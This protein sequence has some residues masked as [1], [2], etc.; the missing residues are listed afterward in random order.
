[1]PLGIRPGATMGVDVHGPHEVWVHTCV[2]DCAVGRVPRE[3]SVCLWL[4]KGHQG[5]AF[6]KW[7]QYCN[8]NDLVQVLGS[9]PYHVALG[10]FLNFSGPQ[11]P[12]LWEVIKG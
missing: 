5:L 11:F 10:N 9:S 1:M 6:K 7:A 3:P 4:H 12:H 8:K 2:G